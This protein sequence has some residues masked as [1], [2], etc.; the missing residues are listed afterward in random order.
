MKRVFFLFVG[1]V[2]FYTLVNILPF[3]KI[4][5]EGL[6]FEEIFCNVNTENKDKKCPFLH[7]CGVRWQETG[8]G[9]CDS[10]IWN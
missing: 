8:A 2:I 9:K 4:N 7:K 1:M 5:N 3:V 6:V 10:V